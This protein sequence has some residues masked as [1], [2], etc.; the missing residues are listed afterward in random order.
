M[1]VDRK[2]LAPSSSQLPLPILHS[3]LLDALTFAQSCRPRALM[4][5]R[6]RRMF[7]AGVGRREREGGDVV[8]TVTVVES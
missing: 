8:H 7:I 5:G 2:R 3:S 6:R 4:R 1:T